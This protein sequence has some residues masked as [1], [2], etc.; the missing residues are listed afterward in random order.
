MLSRILWFLHPVEVEELVDL[1]FAI[2][3]RHI[4]KVL[5][6]EGDQEEPKGQ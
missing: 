1:G 4:F 2:A 5:E 3:A 6:I